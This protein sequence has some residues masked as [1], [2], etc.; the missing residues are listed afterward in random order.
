MVTSAT[1]FADGKKIQKLYVYLAGG[2]R[3]EAKLLG[4][5][6]YYDVAALQ[7]LG[8]P[9]EKFPAANL[10]QAA[11]LEQGRAVAILGRSEAPGALTVNAGTVSAVGRMQ[12]TCHQISALMNY[13]NLGGPVL[14]LDGAVVG[15]AARL[16]PKTAWRQNCGVGF[17]LLAEKINELL[18]DLKAGKK[19]ERPKQPFIGIQLAGGDSDDGAK[20]ARVQEN[21]AAKASGMQ[22]N[23]TVVEFNGK[24]VA[25]GMELVSAIRACEI[26]QKVKVKVKRDDEIE[27]LELTIG[28]KD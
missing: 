17:M 1:P 5:D 27:E 9:N 13:G 21:G 8:E 11:K 6:G 3:V 16:N 14:D 23:D 7:L 15:M 19:L 26:G 18:P 28:E 4:Q 25:N 12:Q 24:K 22:D 20:V 2:R 10:G